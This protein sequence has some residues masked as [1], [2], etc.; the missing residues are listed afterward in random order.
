[1]QD[2]AVANSNRYNAPRIEGRLVVEV[3]TDEQLA[4]AIAIAITA[5]GHGKAKAILLL[6]A[7]P[8]RKALER[9]A[10]NHMDGP[11][12]PSCVD[13]VDGGT[14]GEVRNLVTID[15]AETGERHAE[16][17]ASRVAA[18]GPDHLACRS[19]EDPDVARTGRLRSRRRT[20][21]DIRSTVEVEITRG[22][23]SNAEAIAR[24]VSAPSVQEIATASRVDANVT[25]ASKPG[26]LN[27]SVTRSR[28]SHRR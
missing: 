8:T 28:R 27:R 18:Q 14:D 1:M 17:I 22:R 5:R 4:H 11:C 2:T 12:V 10:G 26:V 6:A 24:R 20:N 23:H 25:L 15:I 13:L 19:G 9:L 3:R 7:A 21:H 16:E